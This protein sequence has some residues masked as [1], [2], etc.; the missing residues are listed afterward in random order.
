[1]NHLVTRV[2]PLALA[3][4]GLAS[5]F[6]SLAVRDLQ[7]AWITVGAYAVAA[8]LFTPSWRYGLFCLGFTAF[9][10][11]TVAY[12]TWRLGGHDEAEALT[13]GLR[14]VVLAWPGS[15]VAGYI[16]PARLADH[17]AQN[18]RLPARPVVA[19]TSAMQQV[20]SLAEGWRQIARTRRARGLAAAG[21]PIARSRTAL[22]MVFA[23]LVMALRQATDRSIAMDARGFATAHHR[24]WVEPA[25]WTLLDIAAATLG[26]AL[27]CVPLLLK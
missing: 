25:P 24:T 17:L 11:L 20:T 1:M 23:L 3:V 6:G 8:L 15:V 19:V 26:L 5:V 13:A 16:D 9:A 18:L 21:G 2:N 14:I 12:S 22:Q 7:T 10:G 27:A 4:L